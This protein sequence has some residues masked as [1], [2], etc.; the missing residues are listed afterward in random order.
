MD[1]YVYLIVGKIGIVLIKLVDF[2][3]DFVL[4]YSLGVV[5]LVCEIV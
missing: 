1:Y 5:E 3:V 2:V 4:V